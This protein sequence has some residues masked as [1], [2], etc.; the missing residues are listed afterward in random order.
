MA[1]KATKNTNAD[2]SAPRFM[3]KNNRADIGIYVSEYNGN[4]YLHVRE[5]Y[6]DKAG[7]KKPTKKGVAL[8]LDKAVELHA[9]LGTVLAE[10]ANANNEAK[11]KASK[12]KAKAGKRAS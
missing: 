2:N 5:H 11:A 4:N 9:L 12:P 6:T 10:I 8:S 1:T 3:A 7:D